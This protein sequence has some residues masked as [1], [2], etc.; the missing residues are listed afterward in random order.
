MLIYDTFSDNSIS[1]SIRKSLQT[2]NKKFLYNKSDFVEFI[3]TEFLTLHV[4]VYFLVRSR[5]R[6]RSH[7]RVG[8]RRE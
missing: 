1:A 3:V 5:F 6:Y 2:E 8:S 4:R 7:S